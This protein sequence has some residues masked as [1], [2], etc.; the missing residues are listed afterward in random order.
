M[1]AVRQLLAV[2]LDKTGVRNVPARKRPPKIQLIMEMH[3]REQ[4]QILLR[5]A[6]AL[7]TKRNVTHLTVH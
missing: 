5:E 2:D 6:L 3:I 1:K 4:T 7:D